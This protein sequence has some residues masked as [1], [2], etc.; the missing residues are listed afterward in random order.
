MKRGYAEVISPERKDEA[1][2]RYNKIIESI[3][4]KES[5]E[6]KLKLT[7]D[8]KLDLSCTARNV[9][10]DDYKLSVIKQLP[11]FPM[12]CA[13]V[14]DTINSPEILG[15]IS[16]KNLCDMLIF[17]TNQDVLTWA[18]DSN[19][20][21][22]KSQKI[23]LVPQIISDEKKEEE[24]YS[25][26][27]E[28]EENEE[29]I[30]VLPAIIS[31]S[32]VEKRIALI[33]E[34]L[35]DNNTTL[36]AIVM[37]ISTDRTI[38]DDFRLRILKEIPEIKS[39]GKSRIISFMGKD[40]AIKAL[41][42][43]DDITSEDKALIISGKDYDDKTMLEL[44]Q[45]VKGIDAKDVAYHIIPHL[46]KDK[47]K[48]EALH[49]DVS[50]DISGKAKAS[51]FLGMK[52]KSVVNLLE[53]GEFP[54]AWREVRQRADIDFVKENFDK[55]LKVETDIEGEQADGIIDIVNKMYETNNDVV[56]D[57][58]FRILDKKYV[59]ALGI[60]KINLISGYPGIQ[61]SVLQ[62]DEK[63]LNVFNRCLSFFCEK[64]P[65]EWNIFTNK[66]LPQLLSTEYEELIGEVSKRDDIDEEC[67]EILTER[68]IDSNW[69]EIKN[70][71]ELKRYDEIRGKK[72]LSIMR[73]EKSSV[74][75]KLEAVIQKCYGHS[76][77][78][79]KG[80]VKRF[81]HDIES[82][83][84]EE[85]KN[86]V[87]ALKLLLEEKDVDVLKEI[88]NN[89]RQTEIED[90]SMERRLKSEFGRQ[91]NEGLLDPQKQD[92]EKI[93]ENVFEAGTDFK[94]LMT[95]FGAFSQERTD[96]Y[97]E[98]WNKPSI[99]SQHVCTSYI[100]NDMIATAPIG[101][102]CYGFS[103]MSDDALLLSG[104]HDIGSG[105]E[106]LVAKSVYD[107]CYY[108]PD[109]QIN[110]TD[111]YNEMD[112]RRVQ[113]GVKKQPD[114]IIVFR[115][116][117]KIDNMDKA[118]SA[119]KDWGG[120]LPI[121]VID[122]DKCLEAE[123]EGIKQ[124]IKENKENP[125]IELAKK[126]VQRASNN[127]RTLARFKNQKD[128]R[129]DFFEGIEEI[130]EYKA[131][132]E[133]YEQKKEEERKIKEAEKAKRL[134]E[135]EAKKV[136][137]EQVKEIYESTTEEERQGLFE[138]IKEK[139][140]KRIRPSKVKADKEEQKAVEAA[141]EQK[142]PEIVNSDTGTINEVSKE[143]ISKLEEQDDGR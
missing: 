56:R 2:K 64:S 87:T 17:V 96:N 57:I 18:I 125:D 51:I 79:A 19:D 67:V 84:D 16:A 53:A 77:E 45:Q 36:N 130:E 72:C 78:Y 34:A 135:K 101:N 106:E 116:S 12:H 37:T 91:F 100:R 143:I 1:E 108:S 111:N 120:K 90:I 60:D 9:D 123:K 138:R 133:L 20:S 46:K 134:E 92:L 68:L 3:N 73:D 115:V 48:I 39:E 121:V 25:L 41:K 103:N 126:I 52:R 27:S 119:Q 129:E 95:S 65:D 70:I 114:Y 26:T 47:S 86:Y 13:Q 93:G 55:F 23:K 50:K 30:D 107:E 137:I 83:N 89:C 113:N 59:D 94:I 81:G 140:L 61:E 104:N 6:E 28:Q 128:A 11:Y 33:K 117:G 127:E 14:I 4:K 98:S 32:N 43:I 71:D 8:S 42:E 122:V 10:D 29:K 38:D 31:I 139:L 54:D 97:K 66:V 24:I 69:C 58:D 5:V 7:R 21:L 109:E 110:H 35:K 88:F 76:L 49:M 85:L 99:K 75:D 142:E 131:Q 63:R 44:I 15:D 22:S 112:Y 132:V 62:L 80:I 136:D 105:T 141:K 82:V 40:T 124:M 102:I 118:L 74:E